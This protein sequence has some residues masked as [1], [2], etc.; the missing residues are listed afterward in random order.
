MFS[1][2]RLSIIMED[3]ST[4]DEF[5]IILYVKFY[6]IAKAK[7]L[8]TATADTALLLIVSSVRGATQGSVWAPRPI[9]PF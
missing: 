8:P 6:P 1:D 2:A 5:S 4:M 7:Q 9:S 3:C